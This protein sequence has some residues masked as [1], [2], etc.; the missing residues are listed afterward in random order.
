MAVTDASVRSLPMASAALPPGGSGLP[1]LGETLTFVGDTYAFMRER[2]QRHGPVFRTS[3]LGQPAVFITGKDFTDTWLDE[4]LIQREGSFPHHV[5]TLFGGRS[6]PLLDGTAHRTRK[7]LVMTALRRDAL[8]DYVPLLD[9]AVKASLARASQAKGQAWI[10]ELKRLAMDGI[11]R[12]I[13]GMRPGPDM[14]AMLEDY[15]KVTRGLVGL[16]IKFPGT[17]FHGGIKA[18]DRIFRRL[19]ALIDGHGGKGGASGA[20]AAPLDGLSRLLGAEVEGVRFGKEDLALE[21][22]HI[23]IAGLIVFAEFACTAQELKQRP[24][25]LAAL[26]AEVAAVAPSGDLTLSTLD[27]MPKVHRVVLETKRFCVNV[28]VSFG[29]TRRPCTFG[30]YTVPPGWLVCMSV[31]ANNFDEKTF[32]NPTTFDPDRF[33]EGRAEHRAHPHAY[34]P[35]GAGK[36]LNH[37]CAGKDFS[38]VFMKVF[39]ARL[40]RDVTWTFPAQDLSLRYSIVPPEPRDGLR[41]EITPKA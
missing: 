4:S 39:T 27:Q 37:R 30:S 28:P 11:L 18:R 35:Q 15:T 19:A 31:N 10:P 2:F 36:D 14:D 32:A 29:R 5:E 6:L 13:F 20:K 21:L 9:D 26:T 12:A 24:D 33:A 22:H 7:R 38:T 25:L 17:A 23:V 3:I 40:V 34:Q 8:A 41:V 16:P 1:L